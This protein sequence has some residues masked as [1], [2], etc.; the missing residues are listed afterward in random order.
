VITFAMV[1]L[2]VIVLRYTQPELK[3]P[4]RIP[5]NIGKFPILPLF[6][7]GVTIYMAIQFDIEIMAVGFGII[8]AGVIFYLIY[9]RRVSYQQP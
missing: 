2:S 1:N 8:A 3:R 5:I 4:F 9:N 7:L 6:G